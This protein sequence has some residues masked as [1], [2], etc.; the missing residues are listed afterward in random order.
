[1]DKEQLLAA[2]RI[3]CWDYDSREA[4]LGPPGESGLVEILTPT[5]AGVGIKRVRV[6]RKIAGMFDRFLDLVDDCGLTGKILEFDGAY[7]DRSVRGSASTRS[8][9]AWGAAFDINAEWNG[10]GQTPAQR[11]ARGSVRELV[12]IAQKCGF[13]WG[14]HF[15]RPDGMHFEPY[16]LLRDDELPT[17]D[18][19][20]T[21]EIHA[22]QAGY[23]DRIDKPRRELWAAIPAVLPGEAGHDATAALNALDAALVSARCK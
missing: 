4:L 13:S 12:G 14:G 17:L 19:L 10:L 5:L 15:R 20:S 11:G 8:T 7:S 9:H 2:D 22:R 23:R 6:H 3:T 1:V 16:R 18:T 21:E